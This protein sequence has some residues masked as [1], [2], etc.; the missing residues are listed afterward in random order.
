MRAVERITHM[1]TLLAVLLTTASC[2]GFQTNYTF[3]A[4]RLWD[5]TG[6]YETPGDDDYTTVITHSPFGGVFGNFHEN[7]QD[8]NQSVIG[9]GS[10]V[11]TGK[12]SS[13]SQGVRMLT[14][15]E[16]HFN[17]HYTETG[18]TLHID[19]KGKGVITL[20]GTNLDG[21][22]SGRACQTRNG[23]TDCKHGAVGFPEV[24]LNAD[25]TGAWQLSLDVT[26][27][28]KAI[29][30]NAT[31]TLSNG[32]TLTFAVSG[33]K[34]TSKCSLRLTGNGDAAGAKLSVT[35]DPDFGMKKASGRLLGQT[36]KV[37]R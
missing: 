16:L 6:S 33:R 23:S 32:R 14:K 11:F 25:M 15:W 35:T 28:G 12:V 21:T 22:L 34:R 37:L 1:K 10:G 24:M 2:F 3:T 30:G 19:F 7:Q 27:T 13:G 4:E 26:T 8:T 20:N 29:A 17:G 31:V 9:S 18:H 5:F 36:I